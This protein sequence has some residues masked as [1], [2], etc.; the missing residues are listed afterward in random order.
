MI[1]SKR[2]LSAE[3]LAGGSGASGCLGPAEEEEAEEVGV[4]A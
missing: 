4:T 3:N 2:Y 1:I